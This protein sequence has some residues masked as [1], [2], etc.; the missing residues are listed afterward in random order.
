MTVHEPFTRQAL[1]EL[2]AFDAQPS[3][4]LYMP[5]HRILAERAQD[6][7]RYKN[8]VRQL[9]SLLQERYPQQDPKPLIEPFLALEKDPSFWRSN[10]DGIA[11][12][13][14]RDYF[15]VIS[16]HQPL[17]EGAFVQS[18]PVLKPLLCL[19]PSLE[20]YQVLCLTRDEVWM[21]EGSSRQLDKIELAPQVPRN[22]NDA[23]G[24]ELT[25]SNQQGFPGGHGRS[26]ERGDSMTHESAG[27]GKQDEINLDRERFFRALDKAIEEHQPSGLPLL[28]VA[29]PE[30]QAVFRA[31][32]H[33]QQLL[34][35][36]INND[37]SLSSVEELRTQCARLI[38][39]IHEDRLIDALNRYG[40]AVGQG[41][42]GARLADIAHAAFDGRVELLLV[43]ADRQIPGTLDKDN[44]T[45]ILDNSGS[46]GAPDVL[47]ELILLVLRQ[48]GEV[49]MLPPEHVMPTGTGAAAVLRF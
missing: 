14:T 22:Q 32:S 7:I 36:G 26:G 6:P 19:E 34:P 33:N 4:S 10:G 27:G 35:K 29:L 11:V 42:A 20:R 30:N 47:E 44:G 43:E 45:L 2:L 48:G 40:I 1:A 12:F 15:K 21:Y 25:P 13:G 31:V 28:L 23:L 3:L 38:Q 46:K 5:T 24:S 17:P 41:L 16:V 8:L 49:V 37:P 9:Q 39:D 18:H